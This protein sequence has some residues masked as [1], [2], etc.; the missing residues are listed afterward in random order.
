MPHGVD[1]DVLTL[2][3]NAGAA[4]SIVVATSVRNGRTMVLRIIGLV[5][6][7]KRVGIGRPAEAVDGR[8]SGFLGPSG[9]NGVVGIVHGVIDGRS[10][11]DEIALGVDGVVS[12]GN[13][14]VQVQEGM[15]GAIVL[16]AGG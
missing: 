14:I 2:A 5:Q 11:L 1:A 9:S 12:G 4:N 10:S 8:R 13:A 6:R 15:V 3:T 7:E 16:I